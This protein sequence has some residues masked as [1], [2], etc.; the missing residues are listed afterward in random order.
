MRL[1]LWI[2][3][4]FNSIINTNETQVCVLLFKDNR[5]R[6]VWQTGE[7]LSKQQLSRR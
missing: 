3:S 2:L 6:K 4:N 5:Y 1:F 7:T